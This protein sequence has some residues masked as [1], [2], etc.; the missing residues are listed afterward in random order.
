[1]VLLAHY[2]FDEGSGEEPS[3]ASDVSGHGNNHDGTYS[4]KSGADRTQIYPGGYNGRHLLV[5]NLSGDGVH[6][7]N[8]ESDFALSGVMSVSFWFRYKDDSNL[9]IANYGSIGET[10]AQNFLWDIRFL[11]N[12][13]IRF[14]WE[15]GAGLNVSAISSGNICPEDGAW[16]HYVLVRKLVG[17]G[18]NMQID[19][20]VDNSLVYNNNNGGP[21]FTPPDGGGSSSMRIGRIPS[22][23]SEEYHI[24]SLRIYDN[25]ISGVDVTSIYNSELN[26]VTLEGTINEM[27]RYQNSD[28]HDSIINISPTGTGYLSSGRNAG[29][30]TVG[31]L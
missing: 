2:L 22:S 23:R 17:A 3:T 18:P 28:I 5:G 9:Y 30:H 27:N 20:Y 13:E 10:Q 15:Y 29:F 1:M 12:Y 7:F 24:D 14:F 16:H 31:T 21:G 25:D 8:N 19:F 6:T 26:L 4:L 11:T